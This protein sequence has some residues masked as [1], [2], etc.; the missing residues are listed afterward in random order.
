MRT[1]VVTFFAWVN[2]LLQ[3]FVN[4]DAEVTHIT[5]LRLVPWIPTGSLSNSF[6]EYPAAVH[7]Y[8][9][10]VDGLRSRTQPH[11]PSSCCS[12]AGFIVAMLSSNPSYAAALVRALTF[13]TVGWGKLRSVLNCQ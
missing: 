6:R 8:T 9:A 12:L 5:Y 11:N 4:T 2:C 3:Q 10:T 13:T 1:H 7:V